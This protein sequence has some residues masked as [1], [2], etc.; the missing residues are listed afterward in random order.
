MCDPYIM[1]KGK[2]NDIMKDD[3]KTIDINQINW[4]MYNDNTEYF[5]ATDEIY[6]CIED[7][8]INL[9]TEYIDLRKKYPDIKPTINKENNNIHKIY[10]ISDGATTIYGTTK[11]SIKYAVK[12]ALYG[13]LNGEKRNKLRNFVMLKGLEVKLIGYIH[14]I[15]NKNVK[16]YVVKQYHENIINKN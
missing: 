12:N 15:L 10:F 11:G 4:E 8:L 9:M 1:V 13:Y 6:Y 14:G 2:I 16:E 3:E 5:I 7:D